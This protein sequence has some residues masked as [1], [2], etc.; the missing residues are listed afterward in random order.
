MRKV[1]TKL[2]WPVLCFFETS[3]EPANYK[4][5]HRVVL[6][7]VGAL[8]ILLSLGS[9]TAGYVSGQLVSLI[10]VVVFFGVGF[11]AVVLGALGSRGAVAKIWGNK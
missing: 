3:E 6:N 10:P 1:L 5:S 7:I 9:A 2:F 8:F 11:V 4:K